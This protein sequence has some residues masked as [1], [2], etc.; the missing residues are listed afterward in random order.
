MMIGHRPVHPARA[1]QLLAEL[2]SEVAGVEEAGLRI[3][4]GLLLE[5]G[6][7][8]RAVDQEERGDGGRKQPGVP[9]P[10]GGERDAECREDEVRGEAL[11]REEAGL[12]Q[13]VPAREVEHGGEEH[14]VEGDEDDGGCQ[15]GEGE[16]HVRVEI[17]ALD[18]VHRPHAASPF[19]V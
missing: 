13:R 16:G 10:D 2:R 6:D 8:Q 7:A 14:V 18:D 9:R 12:P 1:R 17:P 11:G 19:S 15:S 5:G 3:D 4:A